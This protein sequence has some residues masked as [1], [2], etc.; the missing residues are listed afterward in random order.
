VNNDTLEENVKVPAALNLP[1]GKL[2]FGFNVTP[3]RPP[4][5]KETPSSPGESSQVSCVI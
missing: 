4:E 5:P 3:Y 1:F 2:F